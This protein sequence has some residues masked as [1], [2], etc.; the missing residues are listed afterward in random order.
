MQQLIHSRIIS[1]NIIKVVFGVLSLWASAEVSI[2][3]QPVPITMQSLVVMI[4]GL[5]Y[6]P[7]LAMSTISSYLLVGA[8]GAPVFANFQG[9]L[10]YM[11]GPTGGYLMGFWLC[12]SIMPYF[13][14]RYGFSTASVFLNCLL[15]QVLIYVPGMLWLSSFIGTSA[16]IYKG[17]LVYIPSG[18]VK[19]FM[20]VAAVRYLKIGNR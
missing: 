8:I 9:G 2:P 20:L 11:M 14:R 18:L 17:F 15:G 5:T 12:C 13:S 7:H 16:T 10:P 4:I 3:I 19:V 6:T 1:L